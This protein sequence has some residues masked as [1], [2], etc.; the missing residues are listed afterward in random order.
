[1]AKYHV[2]QKLWVEHVSD[3]RYYAQCELTVGIVGRKWVTFKD[4]SRF[5]LAEPLPAKLER[6]YGA[7]FMVYESKE[8]AD[9]HRRL[10]DN[11]SNLVIHLRHMPMPADMTTDKI[12]AA[13]ELL[14]VKYEIV[15]RKEATDGN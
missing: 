2:G 12:I 1:M 14:G 15:N 10:R 6:G 4:G 11:W 13:A 9:R 7:G 8:H 5:N 3:R